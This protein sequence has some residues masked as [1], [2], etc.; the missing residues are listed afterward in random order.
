MA[1]PQRMELLAQTAQRRTAPLPLHRCGNARPAAAT[2]AA[3]TRNTTRPAAKPAARPP[4][5]SKKP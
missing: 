2:P 4:A 5:P 1:V 3:A